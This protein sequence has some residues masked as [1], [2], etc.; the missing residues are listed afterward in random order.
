MV[1]TYYYTNPFCIAYLIFK[2]THIHVCIQRVVASRKVPFEEEK[3]LLFLSGEIRGIFMTEHVILFV[4]YCK[5]NMK[6]FQYF[7]N[8]LKIEVLCL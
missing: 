8:P 1:V 2:V 7:S 3:M 6:Y 4:C 5:S